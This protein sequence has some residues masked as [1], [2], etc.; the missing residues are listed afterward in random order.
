MKKLHWSWPTLT[1]ACLVET[2]PVI[3]AFHLSCWKCGKKIS[4]NQLFSKILMVIYWV[5]ELLAIAWGLKLQSVCT[6][7]ATPLNLLTK[8]RSLWPE[9]VSHHLITFILQTIG[10]DTWENT[11]GGTIEPTNALRANDPGE[12]GYLTLE[13]SPWMSS[14]KSCQDMLIYMYI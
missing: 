11:Q 9:H 3:L 12:L 5:I 8:T 7:T 2:C 1:E 4:S 10:V 6:I 14:G 13:S